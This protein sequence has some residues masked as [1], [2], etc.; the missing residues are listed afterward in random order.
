MTMGIEPGLALQTAV[1]S[2]AALGHQGAAAEVTSNGN[3]HSEVRDMSFLTEEERIRIGMSLAV[4]ATSC[5]LIGLS[6]ALVVTV[7]IALFSIRQ[8]K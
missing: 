2:T 3:H 1:Y 6:L 8:Q 5:V 7:E 4:S